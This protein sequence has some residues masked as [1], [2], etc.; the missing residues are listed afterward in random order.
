MARKF[1]YECG[2][3]WGASSHLNPLDTLTLLAR[4][5]L[6]VHNEHGSPSR[7][8]ANNVKSIA[9]NELLYLNS[10][11]FVCVGLIP[12]PLALRDR[13]SNADSSNIGEV[14]FMQ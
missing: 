7:T 1:V 13:V 2:V 8:P 3:W 5:L 10:H 4:R 14:P 11:I 6:N 12:K 9:A